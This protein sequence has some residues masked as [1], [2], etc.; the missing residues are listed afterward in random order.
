MKKGLLTLALTLSFGLAGCGGEAQS[1][2]ALDLE[3]FSQEGATETL[4][5]LLQAIRQEVGNPVAASPDQCRVVGIGHRPCGGPERYLLF[6]TETTDE[7]RLLGLVERYNARARD[8]TAESGMVGT[9][10]VLPEPGTLVRGGVC[11]AAAKA[12]M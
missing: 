7:Q 5:T 12:E 11:V 9:C 2:S 1:D 6:S 10:E 3:E 8:L 4:D